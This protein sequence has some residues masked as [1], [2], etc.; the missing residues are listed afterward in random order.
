M[1]DTDSYL[2]LPSMLVENTRGTHVI[3]YMNMEFII[4]MKAWKRMAFYEGVSYHIIV[5]YP[6]MVPC[7]MRL[8]MRRERIVAFLIFCMN[9]MFHTTITREAIVF[10]VIF[11]RL[12]F[13]RCI[14]NKKQH[15]IQ[16]KNKYGSTRV[17]LNTFQKNLYPLNWKSFPL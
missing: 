6:G 3:V 13:F 4:K 5:S 11:L 7:A 15:F 2:L 9:P 1:L 12:T 14:Y 17:M 8:S 10:C 16:K